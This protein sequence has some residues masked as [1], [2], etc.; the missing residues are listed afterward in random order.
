MILWESGFLWR[1]LCPLL[2]LVT[3][4]ASSLSA[5]S[6]VNWSYPKRIQKVFFPFN[7]LVSHFTW[8]FKAFS[9]LSAYMSQQ[10]R[11]EVPL[12]EWSWKSLPWKL[13]LLAKICRSL[14]LKES[15]S[16]R[17]RTV[18]TICNPGDHTRFPLTST[19]WLKTLV[20]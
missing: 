18:I 5:C 10:V 15:S 12:K 17:E 3:W 7:F 6:S 9:D 19:V 8:A 13:R 1:V 11:G 20:P 2:V 16:S 4:P 14:Y